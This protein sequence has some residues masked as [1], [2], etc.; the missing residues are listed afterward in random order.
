[1]T[2]EIGFRPKLSFSLLQKRMKDSM[3]LTMV[4]FQPAKDTAGTG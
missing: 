2:S 4:L 3:K 1:M